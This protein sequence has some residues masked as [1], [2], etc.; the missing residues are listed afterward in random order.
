TKKVSLAPGQALSDFNVF[1]LVAEA[2]GVGEMFRRWQSPEAVFGILQQLSRDQPCDITGIE[3]YAMLD[4]ER[5]VQWPFARG[6]AL[7]EHERRLFEDGR[8]FHA[9]GRARLLFETP[10]PLPEATSEAYPLLLL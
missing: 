5:G 4:R 2:W 3:G 6:D 1:R 8:Y 9:D 10:R 7:V